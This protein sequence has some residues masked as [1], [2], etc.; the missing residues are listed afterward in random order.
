MGT[1]ADTLIFAYLGA[2]LITM[3]LPTIEFPEVGVLYPLPQVSQ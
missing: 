3:L 2:H 1:M